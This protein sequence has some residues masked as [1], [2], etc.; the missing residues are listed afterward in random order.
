MTRKLFVAA[1]PNSDRQL[2]LVAYHRYSGRDSIAR[3]MQSLE[4][5]DPRRAEIVRYIMRCNDLAREAE[6]DRL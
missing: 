3:E 5:G 1:S 6:G 2:L 4:P